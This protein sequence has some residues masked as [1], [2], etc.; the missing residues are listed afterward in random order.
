M[1]TN[2]ILCNEKWKSYGLEKKEVGNVRV[3]DGNNGKHSP[4]WPPYFIYKQRI[5]FSFHLYPL[6]QIR[7]KK[8]T[9]IA[10]ELLITFLFSIHV[11]TLIL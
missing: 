2:C 7:F 3:E 1:I 11:Y 6:L 5:M 8:K 10:M 9:I 4:S